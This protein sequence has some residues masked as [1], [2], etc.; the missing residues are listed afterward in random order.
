M[1]VIEL[2]Q[3]ANVEGIYVFIIAD[4]FVFAIQSVTTLEQAICM[5]SSSLA[6]TVVANVDV[7]MVEM[8]NVTTRY[9]VSVHLLALLAHSLT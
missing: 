6:M 5:V 8:W 1:S 2:K 7:A 9:A 3:R 4:T